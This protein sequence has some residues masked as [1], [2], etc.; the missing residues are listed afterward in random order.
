MLPLLEVFEEVKKRNYDI[1][2]GSRGCL[3]ISKK[4]KKE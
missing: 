4:G 1:K 2:F 3:E